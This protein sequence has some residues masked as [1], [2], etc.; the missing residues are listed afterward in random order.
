ML[1]I[2]VSQS[3]I[4]SY[5]INPWNNTQI[6]GRPLGSKPGSNTKPSPEQRRGDKRNPTTPPDAANNAN[7]SNRQK[8]KSLKEA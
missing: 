5:N 6:C 8:Q 7:S 3:V 2:P 1:P 4:A